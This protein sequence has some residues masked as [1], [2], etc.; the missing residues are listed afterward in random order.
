MK[1]MVCDHD[2]ASH[3]KHRAGIEKA[4]QVGLSTG[5]RQQAKPDV[6]VRVLRTVNNG[7]GT[8]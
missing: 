3:V 6:A 1:G 2:I 7:T 8:D 4:Q 5:P